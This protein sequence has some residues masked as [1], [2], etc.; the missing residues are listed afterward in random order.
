LSLLLV[1]HGQRIGCHHRHTDSLTDH[2]SCFNDT[3]LDHR[4]ED[5]CIQRHWYFEATV[6]SDRIEV[7]GPEIAYSPELGSFKAVWLDLTSL[8]PD[9]VIPKCVARLAIANRGRWPDTVMEIDER[10]SY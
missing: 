2:H 4:E 3:G 1:G 9:A 5:G 7:S 8:D 10:E 6:G